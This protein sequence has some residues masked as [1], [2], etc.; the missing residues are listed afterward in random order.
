MLQHIEQD[1][2]ASRVHNAWLKTIEDGIH[3]YDIFSEEH[4][5]E[6]VGT[7]EFAEAVVARLGQE[8]EKL[9]PVKYG[10]S[11]TAEKQPVPPAINTPVAKKTMIG[12]DVFVDWKDA[13]PED[14]AN[15][16]QAALLEGTELAFIDSRGVQ[17]WPT[18][19]PETKC[20]DHWRCRIFKSSGEMSHQEVADTLAKM[21]SND[22]DFVK[23]ESLCEFDGASAFSH[24]SR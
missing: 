8:P 12:I 5:K 4:S 2:I 15:K 21:A 18:G 17:V 11:E 9:A 1:E 19:F 23:F 20:A 6:K 13:S 16:V 14:V 24:R 7:K 3:T 10:A 22:I